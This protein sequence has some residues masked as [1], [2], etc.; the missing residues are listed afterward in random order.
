MHHQ[1]LHT[2]HHMH[3]CIR[4]NWSL[5]ALQQLIASLYVPRLIGCRVKSTGPICDQKSRQQVRYRGKGVLLCRTGALKKKSS[6]SVSLSGSAVFL[7]LFPPPVSGDQ[8][9]SACAH[10]Q[11]QTLFGVNNVVCLFTFI[12]C[13]I[14][15]RIVT[16]YHVSVLAL[17]TATS[18]KT[19]CIM[20]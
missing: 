5:H 7:D 17:S 8:H 3:A 19:V 11:I 16:F 1:A 4:L 20:Q 14:W 2:P 10:I 6:L 13:W 12:I 18:T 9:N 15:T